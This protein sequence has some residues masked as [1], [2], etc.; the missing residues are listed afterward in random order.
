MK[1]VFRI[2]FAV[3]LELS[4]CTLGL[5]MQQGSLL[6]I[7]CYNSKQLRD[8]RLINISSSRINVTLPLRN[9]TNSPEWCTGEKFL[10][11]QSLQGQAPQATNSP[12]ALS[13]NSF[14]Q[15]EAFRGE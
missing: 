8:V 6:G 12:F 7:G 15:A 2:I 3:L 4:V 11:P 9:V 5:K 10:V 14:T 13:V 1:H